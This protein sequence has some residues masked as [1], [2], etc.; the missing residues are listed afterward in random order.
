[1]KF[2]NDFPKRI[3]MARQALNLTQEELAKKV[4]VVRRQI[5]AY[6]GGE[7]K[8][9]EKV[10]YN[11]AAALGT[12]SEWLTSGKGTAPDLGNIRRT[13]TLPEIPLYIESDFTSTKFYDSYGHITASPSDFI[14]APPGASELAFAIKLQGDS[15]SSMHSP[16]FPHGSII[17]FEPTEGAADADFILYGY[18][19]NKFIFRQVILDQGCVYLCPLNPEYSKYKINTDKDDFEIL[20]VAIHTQHRVQHQYLGETLRNNFDSHQTASN[21]LLSNELLTIDK[22]LEKLE[23]MLEQLLDKKAP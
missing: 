5:A 23:S 20:G 10:L 22:R 6:E 17:T 8:P 21:D 11:L 2:Y 3:A 13:V 7:S 9:R 18:N 4:G 1:M 15:M 16:S 14:V 19:G 12:S